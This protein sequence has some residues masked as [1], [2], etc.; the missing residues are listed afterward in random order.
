M[1]K[2]KICSKC[3][4]DKPLT[5]DYFHKNKSFKDGFNARCK[6]CRNED[7]KLYRQ[8][9]SEKIKEYSNKYYCENKEQLSDYKAR[10]YKKNAERVAVRAKRYYNDNRI[11]IIEYQARYR[12]ENPMLVTRRNKMYY[13]NNVEKHR[14]YREN[15]KEK[16]SEY[17]KQY[18][19]KNRE[20][21]IFKVQKRNAMKRKLP[22]TLTVEQ[23]EQARKYFNY[24]CAYCG[25]KEKLEQEHFIPLS[26]G[27]GYT[28]N[29]IIPACKSCNCSKRDKYFYE[30]YH[31]FEHYDKMREKRI[32][33]YLSCENKNAQQLSI[34]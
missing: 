27:G 6:V 4:V 5:I 23:W 10:W 31:L 1:I 21:F 19:K 33:V 26:K 24:E 8:E 28:H 14:R 22:N 20:K 2:T 32:F 34:L 30:W 3:N 17:S 25:K 11:N 12:K 7:K 18:T 29:N 9:N 13:K 15:N 16:L